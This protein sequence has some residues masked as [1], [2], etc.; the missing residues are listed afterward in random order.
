MDYVSINL[1]RGEDLR[2]LI[3]DMSDDLDRAIGSEPELTSGNEAKFKI[4]FSRYLERVDTFEENKKKIY[5]LII[6]QCTPGLT[7]V[8]KSH[9]GYTARS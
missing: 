3:E 2:I 8:M 7:T 9:T 4:M 6:G 5:M 1:K